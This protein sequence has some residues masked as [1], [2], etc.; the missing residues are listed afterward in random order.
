VRV[1]A[2][3]LCLF[4]AGVL[5]WQFYGSLAV[6]PGAALL[7]VVLQL[8]LLIIGFWLLRLARPLRAPSRAWSAA[9]VVWGATAAGGCALLANQGLTGLWAKGAGVTFASNWAP[10]LTAPLNE[11]LLKLAGVA[12]IALAAPRAIRGPM[13]GMVYGAL[14]GLGFQAM[15]NIIYGL[16]NIPMLAATNP[17]AAVTASAVGRGL[18][19]LASHWTMTAVAG[20]G[21]GYL[22]ARGPRR[23]APPAAACLAVAMAMHLQFDAPAPQSAANMLKVLIVLLK[24]LINFGVILVFYLRLRRSYLRRARAALTGQVTS[25]A[26][27]DS[28]AP[29]LLARRGRRRRRH[30]ATPG[31]VRDQ[32]AARQQTALDRIEQEAAD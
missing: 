29:D 32:V 19:V 18:T 25:G 7:A 14:T 12:M 21:I 22:A 28:E 15:E 16:S 30:R 1:T 31:P 24:V 4:G 2:A 23:G 11:E 17:A 10:A 5:V 8:P 6:F 9:A 20:A 3:V 27:P 13:D 26:V